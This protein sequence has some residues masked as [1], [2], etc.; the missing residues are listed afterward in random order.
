MEV[1]EHISDKKEFLKTLSSLVR[2]ITYLKQSSFENGIFKKVGGMLFVSTMEKKNESWVKL[3]IGAE[4]LLNLV[5]K[6]TH[7]WNKFIDSE[8]LI[9]ILEENGLKVL[10]TQGFTYNVLTGQMEQTQKETNYALAAIKLK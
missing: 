3:I 9:A 7:D 5:P 6:G 1:I 10:K 8:D 4:Y 2:V